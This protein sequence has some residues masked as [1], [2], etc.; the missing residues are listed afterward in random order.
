MACSVFYYH[1]KR[2]KDKDK[3]VYEKDLSNPF[4]MNIKVGT[5]IDG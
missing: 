5:A 2:L 4:F 1:F 3:Y